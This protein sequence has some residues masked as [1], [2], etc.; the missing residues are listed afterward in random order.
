M[1]EARYSLIATLLTALLALTG[2]GRA[3]GESSHTPAQAPA[4]KRI[5]AESRDTNAVTRIVFIGQERA[6]DCTRNRIEGSWSALQ[7]ALGQNSSR[8][9]ERLNRDTQADEVEEYRMLRPFVTVPAIY[10]LDN[11]GAIVE[12]LQGEV[13]EEQVRTALEGRG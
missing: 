7:A 9:V 2:C 12:L 6:C 13:T 4:T 8:N 11:N 1:R 10:L 5:A 3:S